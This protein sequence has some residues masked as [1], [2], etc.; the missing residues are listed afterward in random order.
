MD[1]IL[2]GDTGASYVA[3]TYINN[4]SSFVENSTWQQNLLGVELASLSWGDFDNNGLM[5][6]SLTGHTGS[7][8]HRIYNN[9]GSFLNQ[10]NWQGGTLVGVYETGQAMGDYDN[11]GKLDIF[12]AGKE[13]Y[14]TLYRNTSSTYSQDP[15]PDIFNVKMGPGTVWCDV[16]NDST[17]DLILI[18][19]SFDT[20]TFRSRVYTNNITTKNTAPSP[21]STLSANYSNGVLNLSWSAGSDTE[22]PT[23]GLYYNLRV[24]NVSGGHQ[25]VTGVY[26]GGD[27]N[28]YFGNMM[29]RRNILL[30]L[31]NLTG[32]IY[33]SVQTIDTGLKAGSWATERVYNITSSNQSQQNDTTP[34]NLT[35]TSPVNGSEHS[36]SSISVSAN[37]ADV[38]NVTCT[39]KLDSGTA[40]SMSGGGTTSGTV[41]M[42][43]SSV[44]N[45]AHTVYV[46]CTDSRN[47][48][49]TKNSLFTVNVLTPPAPPPSGGGGGGGG[50]TAPPVNTTVNDTTPQINISKGETKVVSF[51]NPVMRQVSL[52]LE[53]AVSSIQISAAIVQLPN[54][55]ERPLGNVY[56][57]IEVK[58]TNLVNP[59]IKKATLSFAIDKSWIYAN[60]IN[61]TKITLNRYTNGVWQ[62]LDTILRSENSTTIMYDA[63]T[64]GLSLFAITGEKNT[65]TYYVEPVDY[66]GYYAYGALLLLVIAAVGGYLHYKHPRKEASASPP[67]TS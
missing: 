38:N 48:S 49:V 61:K 53:N 8:E 19:Y 30:N 23:L 14:S 46:N 57:Y 31:P 18:S 41:S 37:Y 10:I 6:L 12:V 26:G 56:S 67:P 52:E 63:V 2:A 55:T 40:A 58:H 7:D 5:D 3:K 1:L 65:K 42:T 43:L 27:D 62:Q 59:D 54:L 44:A 39:G 34:P 45:G 36:T 28:G 13:Q 9:T 32:T 22:T 47:N 16:N 66:S 50:S 20:D 17:L 15:E 4:G 60:D 24:G 11:N 25:I 64:P 33:W 21:P 51:E 35:I 29:Q